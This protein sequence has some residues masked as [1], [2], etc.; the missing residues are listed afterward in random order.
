MFEKIEQSCLDGEYND[1]AE[2]PDQNLDDGQLYKDVLAVVQT[3]IFTEQM[4]QIIWEAATDE[5]VE[6]GIQFSD[7]PEHDLVKL[8]EKFYNFATAFTA[9][10]EK[11]N[12]E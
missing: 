8:Y 7:V 2:C 9:A 4:H 1:F 11:N 10:Q 12:S 3:P 5:G 6:L